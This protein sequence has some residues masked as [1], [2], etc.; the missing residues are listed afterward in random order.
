MATPSSAKKLTIVA[1]LLDESEADAHGL[2]Q[3]SS[4]PAQGS[5]SLTLAVVSAAST[6]SDTVEPE[7]DKRPSDSTEAIAKLAKYDAFTTDSYLHQEQDK[8]HLALESMQTNVYPSQGARFC[9]P[10]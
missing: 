3:G 8:Q 6:D 5:T 2:A 4:A 10:T 1:S 7:H 9:A